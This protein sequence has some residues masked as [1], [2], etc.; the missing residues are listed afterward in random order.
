MGKK[1]K[2]KLD[3]GTVYQKEEGGT[4][5]FRYQVQHERK[6]VSLKTSNQ[7]EALEKAR[8]LLPIIQ[9]T[10]EEVISAHV[11]V[12]RHLVKQARPLPLSEIWNVYSRH[13]QRAIPATVRVS[14][15]AGR[16]DP[17]FLPLQQRER[18]QG[19]Y[20]GTGGGLRKPS[21]NHADLRGD[22]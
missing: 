9:A 14:L 8:K 20:T 3:V 4:Y 12:A 7:E 11:K 18:C 16:N 21:Q 13:P 10:T 5:Y 2:V 6:C 19:Y 22:P 15:H 17:L 1:C